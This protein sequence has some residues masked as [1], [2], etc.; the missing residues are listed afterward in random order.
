M[1]TGN[2][3]DLTNLQFGCP[4][5]KLKAE[6][7]RWIMVYLKVSFKEVPP[8]SEEDWNYKK[9]NFSGKYPLI[10]LPYLYDPIID[11]VTSFPEA[12]SMALALRWKRE[13][14]LGRDGSLI[15]MQKVLVFC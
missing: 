11:K 14:L 5:T 7:L 1:Q 4:P 13:D 3:T 9:Q 10:S 15:L 2:T 12:I 8:K 6:Y